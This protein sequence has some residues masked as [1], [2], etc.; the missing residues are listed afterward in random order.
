[1]GVWKPKC[2]PNLSDVFL[3]DRWGAQFLYHFRFQCLEIGEDGIVDGRTPPE[4]RVGDDLESRDR[5]GG[6]PGSIP[7][8]SHLDSNQGTEE[9]STPTAT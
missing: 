7:I 9:K 2:I 3:S 6:F 4:H 5:L 8:E 1:M